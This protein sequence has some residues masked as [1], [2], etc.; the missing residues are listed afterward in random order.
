[1][2]HRKATALMDYPKYVKVRSGIKVSWYYYSTLDEA[3]K[4]A[5]AARHN[6]HILA[7][8]GYDFG[9]DM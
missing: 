4:A 6:A 9:R 2:A 3:E 8:Q 7:R 1:M 5:T